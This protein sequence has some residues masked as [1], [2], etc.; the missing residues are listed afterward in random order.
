MRRPPRDARASMFDRGTLVVAVLEGLVLLAAGLAAE[1]MS[2][3]S[4]GN[5]EQARTL[6]FCTIVFGSL[7]LILANRSRAGSAL[8][9]LAG[10]QPALGWVFAGTLALLALATG[11][12]GVRALFHFAPLGP[13]ELAVSLATAV[14]CLVVFEAL[15]RG[16]AVLAAR[17]ARPTG[18]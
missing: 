11:V 16:R 1:G 3:A 15:K 9:R 6:T 12:P 8:G 2:L 17:A 13:G 18:R 5:A 4:G 7:G 10:S 14:G